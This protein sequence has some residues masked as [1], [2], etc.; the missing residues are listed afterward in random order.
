MN[1][2]VPNGDQIDPKSLVG[3][4]IVEVAASFF[5]DARGRSPHPVFYYVRTDSTGWIKISNAPDGQTLRWRLCSK[6][7]D[8]DVQELGEIAVESQE[9]TPPFDAT[10][11]EPILGVESI[12]V[13]QVGA[14]IGV[15]LR[16][17]KR[18]LLIFAWGDELVASE[19]W[20][21]YLVEGGAEVEGTDGTI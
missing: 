14:A 9:N 12:I 16:W 6:P 4:A 15:L 17:A 7:E 1:N 13:P 18:Q 3:T 20:P 10:L 2:P 5:T 11:N 19:T 21:T 8:V